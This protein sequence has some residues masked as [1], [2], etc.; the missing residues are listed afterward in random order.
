[1]N[2]ANKQPPNS[3]VPI[4]VK[5]RPAA[6]DEMVGHA[7]VLDPLRRA[8]AGNTTPH[9]YLF[10]GGA[11]LGKTTLA[12]IV[13]SAVGAEALEIDAASNNGVDDMRQ[14]VEMGNHMALTGAGKR[15]FIIDECHALSKPAWQAI[16]KIVEE[17]PAH[18]FIALCTTELSKVPETIVSRCYHTAL[19]GLKPDELGDLLQV[20]A[21]LEGWQVLPDVLQAVV[22]AAGGSPRKGLSMLQAVHDAPS[23]D[24]VKRIITLMDEGD[25]LFDLCKLIIDGKGWAP[26]Q[27]ALGALEDADFEH[28]GTMAGRFLI[29]CMQKARSE[30]EAR[31][32]WS[33]LDALLFPAETFDRKASFYAAIG[34]MTWGDK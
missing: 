24:E 11:G 16:L 1:M 20:V 32:A 31:R 14:L 27:K 22:Q 3:N 25:P 6:F 15:L 12:R 30:T 19:R 13:A 4:I 9:A 28:A 5:Y 2:A 17:P 18:L 10:T 29:S 33:L 21:E 23:R 7:A 8:I 34:R 26:L